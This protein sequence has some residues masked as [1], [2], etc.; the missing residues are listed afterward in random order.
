[1][2][3]IETVQVQAAARFLGVGFSV[4]LAVVLFDPRRH[5]AGGETDQAHEKAYSGLIAAS[6]RCA[7]LYDGADHDKP[8][9]KVEAQAGAIRQDE[10][11]A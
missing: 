4:L 5:C 2:S 3:L 10:G 8:V 1:M 7:T 11:F 6:R 9:S